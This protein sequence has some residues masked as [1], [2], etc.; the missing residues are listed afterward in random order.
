MLAI[1]IAWVTSAIITVSGGFPSDPK[2]PAYTART[3]YRTSVLKNA[4]WFRVPYPGKCYDSG[5]IIE[6]IMEDVKCL[7]N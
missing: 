1:I 2:K 6:N 4:D 3:D 5:I 7:F